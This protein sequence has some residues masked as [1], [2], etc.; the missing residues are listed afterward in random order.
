MLFGTF[1]VFYR[2]LCLSPTFT[3]KTILA[4]LIIQMGIVIAGQII[5]GESTV[6]QV[7]FVCMIW[8]LW[9]KSFSLIRN[10][11]DDAVTQRKMR[12][13]AVSGIRQYI[14]PSFITF[15]F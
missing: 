11:V 7:T 2:L 14:I 5:T 3:P 15:S 9:Y 4:G 12:I 1:I 10:T 13:M 6:Q 8:Y